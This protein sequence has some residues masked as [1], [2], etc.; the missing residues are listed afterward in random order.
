M[1][2]AHARTLKS[3]SPVTLTSRP[4]STWARSA[5]CRHSGVLA[6]RKTRVAAAA[7]PAGGDAGRRAA[8][9]V[10]GTGATRPPPS[11]VAPPT[12]ALHF[13]KLRRDAEKASS[14]PAASR[15]AGIG[16][17]REGSRS[18][19]I[20]PLDAPVLRECYSSPC[21]TQHPG[22]PLSIST[23]RGMTGPRPP[24]GAHGA[25]P[26][27]AAG[28]RINLVGNPVGAMIAS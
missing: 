8:G 13:R 27:T 20:V 3:G 6:V 23:G 25:T 15:L 4:F 11:A 2:R 5:Q 18:R 24:G 26:R 7:A 21:G 1:P 19:L 12:R 9:R 28:F 16:I 22:R 17:S 14:V 10:P